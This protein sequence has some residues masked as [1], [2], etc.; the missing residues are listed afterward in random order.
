MPA[1]KQVP[2][3]YGL[4]G[5]N[6]GTVAVT[7]VAPPVIGGGPTSQEAVLGVWGTFSTVCLPFQAKSLP[8]PAAEKQGHQWKETDPVIVGIG[9]E[10]KS[11]LHV[12][13]K[14]GQTPPGWS[15]LAWSLGVSQESVLSVSPVAGTSPLCHSP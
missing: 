2:G 10:V 11:L 4:Q 9:E 8:T 1:A 15:T 3:K 6:D 12:F 14:A 7:R 5:M 13:P